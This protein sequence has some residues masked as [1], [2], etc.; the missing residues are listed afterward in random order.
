MNM[1]VILLS[2]C[3]AL[4]TTGNIL[5]VAVTGLIGR[6]LAPDASLT[7]LP[8]AFQFVGLMAATIPASLI[9]RRIGRR[10]GFYLGNSVGIAG[11][12]T[13]VFALQSSLFPLFCLGTFLLGIGIG[14]GTL[15]RFAAVEACEPGQESRAISLVMAGGVLAAILGPNLAV[16]SRQLFS[17]DD[18][19]GAFTALLGLYI[20]ALLLLSRI[21]MPVQDNSQTV[22][23]A[24]P[25]NEILLQPGFISAVVAG[26]VSYTVMVLLM[27]ATPL[28]MQRCGFSFDSAATVIEWHVLGMFVPSFFTGQLINRFGVRPVM[29]CGGILF[30]GCIALNLHGSSEWHFRLALLLLGI[31]WNFMFIGATQ[32]VTKTYT[33]AEKAKTQAANEF[34]IFSMVTLASL[35]AGWMEAEL[36]W[37][38]TSMLM[39]PLVLWAMLVLA[40]FG[41]KTEQTN[42]AASA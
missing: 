13:S 4:L 33:Q 24:R 41:R 23:E 9:M 21:R 36:G 34:L 17:G 6:Q 37:A 28:A 11:A 7:T 2:L 10:N 42:T 1:N 31:G 40:W 14:F 35:G 29:Q 22:G 30:L 20:L 39:L 18:F 16:Y 32:L 27:T 19:T 38:T 15:Y 5:L 12:I 3:Q 8:V 25:L 26:M